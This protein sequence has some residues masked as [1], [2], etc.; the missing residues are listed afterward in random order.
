MDPIR[1]LRSSGLSARLL[2][3][4]DE[5]HVTAVCSADHAAQ[6][7]IA[8]GTGIGECL[9]SLPSS[10]MEISRPEGWHRT[11]MTS[12]GGGAPLYVYSSEPDLTNY[13][14]A[15]EAAKV[16]VEHLVK[17]GPDPG[18]NSYHFVIV[19]VDGDLMDVEVIAVAF[20]R[21]WQPYGTNK[22]QLRDTPPPQ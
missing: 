8:S 21:N 2:R 3:K 22:V 7:S 20:G 19:R 18:D 13:L 5:L 6:E 16:M 17:P 9:R 10:P 1:G 14:R 11:A 4:P 15:N 12:G